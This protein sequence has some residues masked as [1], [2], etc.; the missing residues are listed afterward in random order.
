[1]PSRYWREE[2]KDARKR[3]KKKF[4]VRRRKGKTDGAV[5]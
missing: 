2:E 4:D 1:M 3:T 5:F